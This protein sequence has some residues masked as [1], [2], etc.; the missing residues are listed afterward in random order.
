MEDEAWNTPIK[1]RWQLK[2]LFLEKFL[3]D[4]GFFNVYC[5]K[6]AVESDCIYAIHVAAKQGDA[7]MVKML[8]ESGANPESPGPRG[9]TP[10]EIATEE[11]DCGSHELVMDLLREAMTLHSVA[12]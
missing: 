11:N 10:L 3:V 7:L 8:L 5:P 12:F 6:A 4:E 9:Q 1:K 2:L